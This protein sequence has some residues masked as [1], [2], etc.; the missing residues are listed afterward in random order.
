MKSFS[1]AVE[2]CGLNLGMM[3][4]EARNWAGGHGK[5]ES[6]DYS[7][8]KDSVRG[9]SD[10]DSGAESINMQQKSLVDLEEDVGSDDNDSVCMVIHLRV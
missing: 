8:K 5:K 3:V 7:E 6:L 10:G 1:G 9:A 2:W 4:Q